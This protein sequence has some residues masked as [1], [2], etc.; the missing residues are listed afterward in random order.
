LGGFCLKKKGFKPVSKEILYQCEQCGQKFNYKAAGHSIVIKKLS[1]GRN[2][3]K[4]CRG[5][6]KKIVVIDEKSDPN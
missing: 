5:E 1:D 4:A 3:L 6:L 2:L